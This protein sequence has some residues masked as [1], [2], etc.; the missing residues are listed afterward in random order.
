MAVSNMLVWTVSALLHAGVVAA[1]G[2]IVAG[3]VIG[4]VLLVLGAISTLLVALVKARSAGR[5]GP[6]R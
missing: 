6:I 5:R 4:V 1:F 2:H 3:A